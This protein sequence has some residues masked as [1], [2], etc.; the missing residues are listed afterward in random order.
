MF[1]RVIGTGGIGKGVFFRFHD[2]RILGRNESRS[3]ELTGDKDFCKQHIVLYYVSML[4][5]ARVQVIPIGKVGKD[6]AGLQM[7]NMMMQA[8]M[9]TGYIDV[10]ERA[11]TMLSICLQY[12]DKCGCNITADNSACSEVTPGYIIKCLQHIGVDS[13]TTV[14][15]LPEVPLE[16]RLAMLQYGRAHSAFTAASLTASEADA[17]IKS[18]GMPYCDLLALNEEEAAAVARMDKITSVEEG[19]TAA[20]RIIR[21][22]PWLKL[23]ITL[24]GRGSITA[25]GQC[26]RVYPPMSHINAINTGGAGDASLGGLIAGLCM[27]LPFHGN[28]GREIKK[29]D[30]CGSA[31]ELGVQLGGLS[32][33]SADSINQ[34]IDW[35]FVYGLFPAAVRG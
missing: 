35:K 22:Y 5:S 28:V 23:W 13:Q 14:I 31:A 7:K 33:E 17:F 1:R 15:A 29:G 25:D 21:Q 9:D 24:G 10:S 3:A 11:P 16:S 4:L 6:E 8:G 34:S 27:G 20:C 12:P 2:D 32:I 18:D 30:L 19:K 26:I